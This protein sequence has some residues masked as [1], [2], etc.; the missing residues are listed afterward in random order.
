MKIAGKSKAD[1]DFA[2]GR[3]SRAPKLEPAIQRRKS[4]S[5]PVVGSAG[6]SR[7]ATRFRAS[8]TKIFVMPLS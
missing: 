7:T 6:A 2:T 5:Q 8:D 3:S 1:L 4:L